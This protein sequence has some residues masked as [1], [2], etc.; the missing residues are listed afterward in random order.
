[1]DTVKNCETFGNANFMRNR[2]IMDY[3]GNNELTIECYNRDIP[4]SCENLQNTLPTANWYKTNFDIRMNILNEEEK[5]LIDSYIDNGFERMNSDL[6][7]N[8]KDYAELNDVID[9]CNEL[10]ND[11]IVFRYMGKDNIKFETGP[12]LNTGYLS[13]SLKSSH[14]VFDINNDDMILLRIK[15]PKGTKCIYVSERGEYE[16][17]LPHLSLFNIVDVGMRNFK[18]KHMGKIIDKEIYFIDMH[19][20]GFPTLIENINSQQYSL[21]LIFKDEIG[22]IDVNQAPKFTLYHSILI[23]DINNNQIVLNEITKEKDD[24]DLI[25]DQNRN[26]ISILNPIEFINSE[27]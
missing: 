21:P 20:I 22:F 17:I 8:I 16:I 6:R 13:T 3:I 12:Y 25:L 4:I 27:N 7:Y 11:I 15:I 2:F 18:C 19:Y 9:K 5:Q 23:I 26:T 1:M 10:D 14:I 24:I